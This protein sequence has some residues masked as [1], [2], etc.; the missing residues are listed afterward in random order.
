M[1]G[2]ESRLPRGFARSANA[3]ALR[4]LSGELRFPWHP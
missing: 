1:G 4:E 2:C 3:P